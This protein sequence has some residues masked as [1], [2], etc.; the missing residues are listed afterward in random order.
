MTYFDFNV[1]LRIWRFPNM[2]R[3]VA[4]R[5]IVASIVMMIGPERFVSISKP[6]LN[7]SIDFAGKTRTILICFYS[8]ESFSTGRLLTQHWNAV[9]WKTVNIEAGRNLRKRGNP[10]PI[11]FL[12][13][14]D[15]ILHQ[16]IA[17]SLGIQHKR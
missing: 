11:R 12:L 17:S 16:N 3:M 15:K 5:I 2:K 9:H 7:F 6:F 14:F 4:A 8:N 10:S 13:K 1:N